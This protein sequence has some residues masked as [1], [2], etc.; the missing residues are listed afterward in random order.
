MSDN[1]RGRRVVLRAG[2]AEDVAELV[3]I[4]S[5]PDVLR[6]W[7]GDGNLAESVRDDLDDPTTVG[8]VIT[9]DQH[10]V[11]W[12]QW[13]EESDPDYRHAGVDIYIDPAFH[14]RGY[15]TD[16][17]RTLVRHLIV[18]HAHHRIV[19]D[20]AADNPAAIRTYMKVGFRPVGIMRQYERDADGTFHDG[21][22]LDMLAEDLTDS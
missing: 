19:I 8:Y 18:D 10:V 9:L 7:R 5:T 14:G 4:R 20:P 13:S 15:G 1:L 3:R 17:I 22:L 6:R 21:L 11:G 16:A 2:T 12:I